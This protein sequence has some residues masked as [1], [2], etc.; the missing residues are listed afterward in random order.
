[1]PL[2]IDYESDWQS[3]LR[4][5]IYWQ[6][7]G[8][9]KIQAWVDMVARQFQDIEDALQTLLTL[10][11]IDDSAGAQLDL[12]GRLLGQARGGV[13][14]DTYRGYLRAAILVE[15]SSGTGE[16]IY[17][18]FTLL[19]AP[20]LPMQ[21]RAGDIGRSFALLIADTLTQAQVVIGKD[22]L[23]RSKTAGTRGNLEYTLV[24]DANVLRFDVTGQGFGSTTLG[25]AE[26]V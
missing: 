3:R 1:V 5:R 8:K 10:P 25:G 17:K 16:S 26:G 15:R 21:I 23:R 11:S 7:K 2:T 6:F 4:A 20:A 24:A 19:L 14:D 22:F 18:I 13:D 12:I 9:P